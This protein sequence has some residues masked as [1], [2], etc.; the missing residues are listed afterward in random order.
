MQV[1][2]ASPGLRGWKETAV[3]FF[4]TTSF[5]G[6]LPASGT[7][8]SVPALALVFLLRPYPF[9]YL[10]AI[11]ALTVLGIAA[12]SYAERFYA[13][14][15]PREVTVDEVVGMLIAL[16]GLPFTPPVVLSTF[17]LYRLFD[18]VKPFPARRFEFLPV[19]FGI[20]ADDIVAGFYANI[21]IHLIAWLL[22]MLF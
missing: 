20:M 15:D 21:G 22:R 17:L 14:K 19:G 13:R 2:P 8:A 18:V 1:K 12:S 3:I 5:L 10:G 9:L 4:A 6:Y 16:Y 11:V 7:V